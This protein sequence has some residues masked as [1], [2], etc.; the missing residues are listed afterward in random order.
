M[1]FGVFL[2]FVNHKK[3]YYEIIIKFSKKIFFEFGGVLF[4]MIF[5]WKSIGLYIYLI[6]IY[7]V[8]YIFIL[9]LIGWSSIKI[10]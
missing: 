5:D 9:D 7:F 1:I 6:A 2:I 8:D 4:D 10:K 3:T